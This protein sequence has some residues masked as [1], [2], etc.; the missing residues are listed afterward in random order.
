LR[1]NDAA[2]SL[3]GSIRSII[4]LMPDVIQIYGDSYETCPVCGRKCPYDGGITDFVSE[5][6]IRPSDW[7]IEM[8]RP[9]H[10]GFSVLAGNLI[11]PT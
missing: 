2:A 4:R 3:M 1:F 9:E 7:E 5:P 10:G 8:N 11:Q 6:V